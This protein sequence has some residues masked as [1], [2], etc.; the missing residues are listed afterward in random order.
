MSRHASRHGSRLSAQA[1][2]HHRA[3]YCSQEWLKQRRVL[4]TTDG[5]K[6]N[7]LKLKPPLVFGRDE[8]DHLLRELTAVLREE[9]PDADMAA[10]LQP[11]TAPSAVQA[12]A[13]HR[14][15][16]LN[17]HQQQLVAEAAAKKQ[18]VDA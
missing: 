6:D 3:V 10:L 8:A 2:W 12:A 1:Q 18:R 16:D 17:H 4:V 7:V 14:G 9:L 11:W 15:G 13:M 5:P